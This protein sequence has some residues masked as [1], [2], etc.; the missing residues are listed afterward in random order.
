ME[1]AEYKP[2]WT[3]SFANEL[4]RLA[5][6]VGD[7][8]KGT[9]TMY[10]IRHDQV[11]LDRRK[12]VT[13]GRI[14]VDI[15][16]QKAEKER[17][18]LTVG[19]DRI[20]YLGKT[21]TETSDLTTSKLLINSTISTPGAR[22]AVIDVKN[23]YLGTKLTRYEY[24]RLPINILPDEIVQQYELLDLVH[25]GYVYVEIQGGM[26]GLP[27]AGL[28]A[29]QLL[30][31]RLEKFG[32]APTIHIPGLWKHKSRPV[33]FSLVVDDFGIKYVGKRHLQHLIDALQ[34][35]YEITIDWEGKKYCG[36]SLDW[37]YAN[38]M[39]WLSM[40][41]YVEAALRQF[42]HDPPSKPTHG[43]SHYTA[44]VYG[45]HTQMTD[46]PD[47]TPALT[48][49]QQKLLQRVVGKFLYYGRAVDPQMLHA[50]SVLASKQVGRTQ[51]TVA[52]MTHFLDFCATHPDA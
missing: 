37:D 7:R 4:G 13:Y 42:L 33:T 5:Q 31:K 22:Y 43:P 32:Y 23:Y 34:N 35:F 20:N 24:M 26:Y 28:L 30:T 18:R 44:P 40:P 11:P 48:P 25:N 9:N 41:G 39:V 8:V 46:A 50:L 38:K 51:T 14:V 45:N 19:G 2:Q 1:R 21:S 36:V 52:A 12:D 15:R 17:T 3:Q 49:D 29:N 16:P 47:N 27:Q 10:F 6:G